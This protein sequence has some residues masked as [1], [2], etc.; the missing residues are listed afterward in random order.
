MEHFYLI[1]KLLVI[2]W[3]CGRHQEHEVPS[4]RT[5]LSKLTASHPVNYELNLT[6]PTSYVA[7]GL[8]TPVF[9]RKFF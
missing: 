9:Y 5:L 2:D 8:K 6:F 4:L 1:S 7:L 3:H